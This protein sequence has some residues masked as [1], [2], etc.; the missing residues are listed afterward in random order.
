MIRQ[1]P[2]NQHTHTMFTQLIPF[3]LPTVQNPASSDKKKDQTYFWYFFLALL[4][5]LCERG[6]KWRLIRRKTVGGPRIKWQYLDKRIVYSSFSLSC[7]GS[8]PKRMRSSQIKRRGGGTKQQQEKR[9]MR[10]VRYVVLLAHLDQCVRTP[11]KFTTQKKVRDFLT[12]G[13]IGQLVVHFSLGKNK[14]V[15]SCL[16]TYITTG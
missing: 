14:K 3:F 12:P 16:S 15:C 6:G 4:L 10:Y 8:I 11:N 13:V 5:F 9:V 2:T 1:K 7:R